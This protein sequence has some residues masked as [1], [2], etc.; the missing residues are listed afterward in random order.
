MHIELHSSPL[1]A[2]LQFFF[3]V[4]SFLVYNFYGNSALIC[5]KVGE[6]VE[7]KNYFLSSFKSMN[8]KKIICE[9]PFNDLPSSK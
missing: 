9:C 7:V 5:V 8:F 1:P 4:S 2:G 6:L 3:S